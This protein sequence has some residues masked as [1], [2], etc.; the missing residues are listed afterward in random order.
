MRAPSENKPVWAEEG[1]LKP[2]LLR[3]AQ[4]EAYV[5]RAPQDT[6]VYDNAMSQCQT[7]GQP[8]SKGFRSGL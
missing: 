1:P 4:A 7:I 6:Y 8:W 5:P 2:L 3:G